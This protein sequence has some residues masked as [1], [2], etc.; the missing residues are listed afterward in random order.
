M[1]EEQE[2]EIF[3]IVRRNYVMVNKEY[4]LRQLEKCRPY[5]TEPDY[6]KAKERLMQQ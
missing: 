1:T 6:E 3:H 5:I 4:L 2:K